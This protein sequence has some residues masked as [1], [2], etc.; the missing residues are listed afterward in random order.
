MKAMSNVTKMYCIM[1][2]YTVFAMN[3]C[4]AMRMGHRITNDSPVNGIV[5]GEPYCL[6]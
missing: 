4:N 3:R 6:Y 1:G 2:I 5:G